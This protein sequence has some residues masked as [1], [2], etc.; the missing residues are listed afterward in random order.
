MIHLDS[1]SSLNQFL[2]SLQIS[3]ELVDEVL[4]RYRPRRIPH[5]VGSSLKSQMLIELEVAP[6][7]PVESKMSFNL[8]SPLVSY[9][10]RSTRCSFHFVMQIFHG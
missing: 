8:I 6:R 2:S 4:E 7:I 3:C 1:D 9:S 5:L 10:Q